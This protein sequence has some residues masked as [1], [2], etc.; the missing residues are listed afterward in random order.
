MGDL[1]ELRGIFSILAGGGLRVYLGK[2][3]LETSTRR[4]CPFLMVMA[5]ASMSTVKR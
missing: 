5:V 4:R 3:L 2:L 1:L